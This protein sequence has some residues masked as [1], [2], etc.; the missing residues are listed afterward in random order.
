M[1]ITA[2]ETAAR[3]ELAACYR[4]AAQAGM[5]DSIYAHISLRVPGEDEHF[6]INPF[7][8]HFEEI[9]ASCLAKVDAEGE[10]LADPTG[11]GINRAGFVIHSAIHQA[12]PDLHCVMHTHTVAGMVLSASAEGLLPLTQHAMRFFES[13]GYH[14][15]EGIAVD[16]DERVRLARD[17]GPH[18]ALVLRNHGLI[19]CGPSVAH[20]YDLMVFLERAAEA[21]WRIQAAGVPIITPSIEAARKTAELFAKPRRGAVDRSWQALLRELDRHGAS[22]RE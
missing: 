16:M 5:T 14:D 7:G 20:A 11:L 1:T 9:T 17:L 3:I 13:I 2:A 22:Y 19:T 8:L 15:Y 6:L 12:R 4:I 10:L 21:Q 18:S